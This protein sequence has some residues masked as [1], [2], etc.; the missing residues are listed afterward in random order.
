MGKKVRVNITLD[1]EVLNSAKE[2]GLNI[3][4]VS[5]NALILAIEAMEKVYGKNQSGNSSLSNFYGQEWDKTNKKD[6]RGGVYSFG[7]AGLVVQGYECCLGMA[8][9][10][11]SIPSQST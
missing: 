6:L 4:K 10:G 3:S 7:D 8:E 5:E 9:V 2:L 11:G 1:D